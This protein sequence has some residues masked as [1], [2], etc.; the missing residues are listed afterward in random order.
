MASRGVEGRRR[1]RVN[2]DRVDTADCAQRPPCRTAIGSLE[3]G[4]AARHHVDRGSTA[5]D[6]HRADAG[7]TSCRETVTGFRPPRG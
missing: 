4:V 6:G 3:N 7:V 5:I 2:R 1:R